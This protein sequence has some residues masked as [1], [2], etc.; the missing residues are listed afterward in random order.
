MKV[1]QKPPAALSAALLLSLVLLLGQSVPATCQQ[2][3]IDQGSWV[4]H[5]AYEPAYNGYTCKSIRSYYNCQRNGRKDTGY[6]KYAWR[7]PGC[8]I[9]RFNPARLLP[10]MRHK[11]FMFVG[12][13]FANNLEIS[14]RCLLET[15]AATKDLRG[16]FARTG[17]RTRGFTI[18]QFNITFLRTASNFLVRSSPVGTA[19]SAAAWRVHLDRPDPAWAALLPYTHY[20]I[21]SAGHWFINAPSDLRLYYR[22]KK[23]LPPFPRP[24]APLYD[25]H[26]TIRKYLVKSRYSGLPMVMT[27]SAYHYNNAFSSGDSAKSCLDMRGEVM[28][29]TRMLWAERNTETLAARDAQ[30]K[31]FRSFPQFKIVDIARSSLARPDAHQGQYTGTERPDCSHWCVPGVPDSWSDIVYSYMVGVL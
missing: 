21:F 7:S 12:D 23:Q 4:Y 20:V 14:M 19:S 3:R 8:D 10:L 15:R 28:N 5:G 30:V 16:K 1:L 26:S 18:P 9:R 13:S 29:R 17:I 25:A 22:K 11:V 24:Y 27:F 31:A 2:C 6:L